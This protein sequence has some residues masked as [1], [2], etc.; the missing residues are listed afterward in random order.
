[1]SAK[2]FLALVQNIFQHNGLQDSSQT[3]CLSTGPENRLRDRRDS[4]RC[5]SCAISFTDIEIKEC[6]CRQDA[7]FNLCLSDADDV[8]VLTTVGRLRLDTLI[9]IDHIDRSNTNGGV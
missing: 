3:S 6:F 2:I 7:V 1:M 5:R 4:P 9:A 8:G